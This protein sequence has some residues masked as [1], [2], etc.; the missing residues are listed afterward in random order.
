MARGSSQVKQSLES[1]PDE[2]R[3][4][5]DRMTDAER[6]PIDYWL[7]HESDRAEALI[8]QYIDVLSKRQEPPFGREGSSQIQE[9]DAERL[10]RGADTPDEV[11][12]RLEAFLW[13][14]EHQGQPQPEEGADFSKLRA[15][16]PADDQGPPATAAD[17]L[18]LFMVEHLEWM[19]TGEPIETHPASALIR[20]WWSAPKPVE[21]YRP[22]PRAVLANFN[23]TDPDRDR[24]LLS[25][26]RPVPVPEGGQLAL[27]LPEL[28]PKGCASWLM[29]LFDRAGGQ[30]MR[31]GTRRTLGHAS[32]CR[33]YAPP[34]HSPARRPV[35]PPQ[36]ACRGGRPMAAPRRL[37][38]PRSRL[39]TPARRPFPYEQGARLCRN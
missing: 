22:N 1:L 23:A 12:E 7:R 24:F 30:S 9:T 17:R 6:E 20:D 31:Q 16:V 21:P 10:F 25:A 18:Y 11:I 32:V 19:L 27:D 5:Y 35:A 15:L 8:A 34:A 39:A 37:D 33:R 38:K 4:A 26:R 3:A 2:A 28:T 14:R 13:D 36:F 29:D